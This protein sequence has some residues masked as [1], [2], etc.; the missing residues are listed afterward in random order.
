MITT[1]DLLAPY[2][3]AN[4]TAKIFIPVPDRVLTQWIQRVGEALY[5]RPWAGG[6]NMALIP[7]GWR[8]ANAPL[9]LELTPVYHS[10]SGPLR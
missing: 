4:A 3:M 7:V 6:L 1:R 5:F 10:I 9:N 8:S 2:G